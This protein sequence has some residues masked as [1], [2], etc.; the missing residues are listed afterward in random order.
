[1]SYVLYGWYWAPP[2]ED[3]TQEEKEHN[4]NLAISF[5]RAHGFTIYAAAGA[6]GNAWAESQMN[7]GRWQGDT[8]YS[9]GYGLMQWTPYTKYSDWA[10]AD[11]ENNGPLECERLIYERENGLQFFPSTQFPQ[12]T[13]RKYCQIVPEEGLTDNET[14]NLC[15][16]IWVYN[17]LRPSDPSGSLANRKY[18]A[19]YVFEH[20]SGGY[21]PPWLLLWWSKRNRRVI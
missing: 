8:P 17:Y 13:Y 2:N 6:I 3:L 9:G 19:R 10:G 12:W 18:H 20:C 5:L 11:W 7:P 4:A 21:V 16:E 1:M 14:V 15:A